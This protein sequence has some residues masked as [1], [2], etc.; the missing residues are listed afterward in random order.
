MFLQQMKLI[1]NEYT[2]FP[3]YEEYEKILQ[4]EFY[5]FPYKKEIYKMKES[6]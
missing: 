4:P 3:I 2:I 5:D 1:K 6:F